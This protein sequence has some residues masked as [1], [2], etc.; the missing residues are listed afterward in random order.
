DKSGNGLPIIMFGNKA[1]ATWKIRKNGEQRVFEV[2]LT[3]LKNTEQSG[4]NI[5]I[6][7]WCEKLGVE[8]FK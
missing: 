8:Y 7:N 2:D 5:A 3:K 1:I 4:L 6:S